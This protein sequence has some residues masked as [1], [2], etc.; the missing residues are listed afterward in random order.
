MW[1]LLVGLLLLDVG[2]VSSGSL[3]L[4]AV[5][6][7]CVI[8]YRMFKTVHLISCGLSMC[9]VYL[10]KLLYIDHHLYVAICLFGPQC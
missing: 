8:C 3:P 9:A 7:R 2:L 1:P 10:L 4:S 6:I 5:A